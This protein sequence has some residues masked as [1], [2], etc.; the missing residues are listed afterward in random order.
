MTLI[1]FLQCAAVPALLTAGAF[2]WW[3]REVGKSKGKVGP[4]GHIHGMMLLFGVLVPSALA[5]A[6]WLVWGWF[7]A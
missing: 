1:V 3:C 7:D 4:V 2:A 5:W 6:A